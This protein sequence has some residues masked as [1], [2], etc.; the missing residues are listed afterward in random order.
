MSSSGLT[1][2]LVLVAVVCLGMA[3]WYVIPGVY[4][5][6]VFSGDVNSQHFKHAGAFLALAVLSGIATRFVRSSGG[7]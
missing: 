2:I 3:I 4:H 6:L 7:R 1:A 5:P